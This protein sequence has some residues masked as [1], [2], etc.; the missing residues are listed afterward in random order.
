MRDHPLLAWPRRLLEGL[1][2]ALLPAPERQAFA[3]RHGLDAPRWS[4]A[5][6][7]LQAALGA[8]LFV[9]NGL[10]F[11]RAVSSEL[12]IK[13]L[14]NWDPSL[15]STHFRGTGMLGWLTWLVWPGSWPWSY[16][17]VVGLIRC[18]SFGITREAVGEPLLIPPLRLLQAR[19]RRRAEEQRLREL[20]P[21]RA[22]RLQR[23]GEELWVVASR[24]KPQWEPGSTTV[25]I[26]GVYFRVTAVE[27]RFNG[28]WVELVYRLREA[29]GTTAIR[30]LVRYRP[31][32]T[33]APT[34]VRSGGGNA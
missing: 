5:L 27:E 32:V 25:E 9:A 22:D 30:R 3:R 4:L 6:G 1:A 18:A 29:E 13:L 11:M 28:R 26:D 31:A 34:R 24:P 10:F 20:G 15:T 14:E 7:L 16:L 19:R 2:V 33:G 23:E 17:L 12:S 21:P 8:A